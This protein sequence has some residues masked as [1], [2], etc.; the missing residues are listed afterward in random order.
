MKKQIIVPLLLSSYFMFNCSS[1]SS[2][3]SS[4]DIT[5]ALSA[6]AKSLAEDMVV[7]SP[8]AATSY[9]VRSASNNYYAA[10]INATDSAN[11]KVEKLEELLSQTAPASCS[12][13]LNL[14]Q[15]SRANCYGPQ[16]NFTA[17][18]HDDSSGQ[19]PTGDLGIWNP[20]EN[21]EACI[22][23]QLSGQMKGAVSYIDLA[24]FI[25]AGIGCVA[26]KNSLTFPASEGDVLDVTSNMSNIITVN[27]DAL[28]VTQATVTRES[29]SNGNPVYVTYLTGTTQNSNKSIEI[30][31]KH[32]S[33]S[34]DDSL[35]KGKI[36]VKVTDSSSTDGASLEYE[37]QSATSG[38]LLLK[39]IRFNSAG[40]NPFVSNSNYSV[41]F[42]KSWSS[43]GEQLRAEMN[44]KDYT[45]KY[46]YAWQAGNGDSHARVFNVIISASNSNLSGTGFFGFG[47]TV[48]NEA[49][50]ID[51]MICAWTGPGHSHSPATEVQRQNI[52]LNN[53]KFEV[54]GA[55]L[56][57]FDPV[58]S[59]ESNDPDMTVTA[60]GTT[61]TR[62]M[63]A[64]IKNLA[65]LS[66]VA[67][68][69]GSLPT[70]P[71]AIE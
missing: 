14:I 48:Q 23:A 27:Q 58:P 10:S 60:T 31:I 3:S 20:T 41:D 28:T 43:T 35:N 64:T 12:I 71:S 37:K 6:F 32:I 42:S 25:G 46:S 66:D 26:N 13:A 22:S 11:D 17:H 19:L 2:N 59:C 54:S 8:T 47:P 9:T 44:P 51:G 49:G 40:Q 24:Q 34:A 30:R 36:S 55:S 16:V 39:K 50:S 45:G 68:V 63:D 15:S 33:L 1:S 69:F 67:S 7:S 57:T 4:S 70:L 56:T 61:D 21:G 62:E 52:I 18:A 5:A 29:N 38:L 65:P 53:G